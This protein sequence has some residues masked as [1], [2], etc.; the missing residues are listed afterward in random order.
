MQKK[1]TLLAA[2]ALLAPVA[3]QAADIQ[4][5]GAIDTGLVFQSVDQDRAGSDRTSSLKMNSSVSAPNRWG[6]RSTEDLG[7]GL[8]VGFNLEGQFGSDDGTMVNSRLFQRMSQ[9]WVRSDTYGTLVM[10]RS[11]ALRSGMGTTGIWGPKVA[12]FSNSW[13][14]YLVG[15]KYI[16]PGGFGGL[17]NAITWQSPV[18]SGMQVHLQYSSKMNQVTDTT[19]EEF[20]G[21]SDRT[22]AAGLT[23]TS[24]PLH[25]AAVL[26]SILYGNKDAAHDYDDS[27]MGSVGAAY[28][29]DGWKLFGSAAAF[30]GMK[31][32]S[33][34]G[35][36][37]LGTFQ[38]P[39]KG[40]DAATYKGY[41]LQIGAEVKAGTGTV[42][43]NAGWMDAQ[44]DETYTTDKLHDTDRIGVAA[45]YVHPLSKRTSFYAGAGVTRTS[46]SVDADA[47]PIVYEAMTGLLHLF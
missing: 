5:Y 47:T 30:T 20:E 36:K 43:L 4:I 12:A 29:F 46:S 25:V 40:F 26:D 21:S 15:S 28:Q 14:D 8:K 34:L 19:G 33:F 39:V 13:G 42:K 10:G 38:A 22:W 44:V 24:G 2:A 9:I 16:M 6:L 18:M 45:G 31:G 35:H 23:Y 27:L 1:L 17:D 3:S 32:S 37:D 7:N 41:S 11:G